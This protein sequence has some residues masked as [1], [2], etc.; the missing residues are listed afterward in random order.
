MHYQAEDLDALPGGGVAWYAAA[1]SAAVGEPLVGGFS[2]VSRPPMA[3][4]VRARAEV[5]ARGLA[6]RYGSRLRKLG[7]RTA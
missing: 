4:G 2:R 1:A 7:T 6:R 3:S 5:L